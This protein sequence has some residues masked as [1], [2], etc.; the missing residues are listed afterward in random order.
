MY[1]KAIFK[2]LSFKLEIFSA[3]HIDKDFYVK[4]SFNKKASPKKEGVDIISIKR[5]LPCESP[6][7]DS[8]V[9]RK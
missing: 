4:V 2:T 3:E 1:R 7:R 5:N 8:T 6:L 9:R